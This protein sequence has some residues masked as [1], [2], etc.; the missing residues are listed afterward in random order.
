MQFIGKTREAGNIGSYLQQK[1][2]TPSRKSSSVSQ[3][4]KTASPTNN[5]AEGPKKREA[6]GKN[7]V[8]QGPAKRIINQGAKVPET[9]TLDR[10][11]NHSL[12]LRRTPQK[13]EETKTPLFDKRINCAD[14]RAGIREFKRDWNA[15]A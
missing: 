4:R 7:D 14:A 12:R 13:G 9:Q 8:K 3:A 1:P 11:A 6:A 5:D 10:R 2:T 15:T